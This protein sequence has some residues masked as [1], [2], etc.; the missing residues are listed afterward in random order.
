VSPALWSLKWVVD[1]VQFELVLRP[2]AYAK[3]CT[4]DEGFA[5]GEMLH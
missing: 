1:G 5:L 3:A 4:V 2:G